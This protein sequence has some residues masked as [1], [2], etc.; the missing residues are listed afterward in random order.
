MLSIGYGAGAGAAPDVEVAQ[1]VVCVDDEAKVCFTCDEA[2][3]LDAAL[4][5][6]A[7]A[8]EACPPC[9]PPAHAWWFDALVGVAAA[10]VGL[11]AGVLLAR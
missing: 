7:A 5:E 2:R 3:D 4:T 9:P 8:A 1:E 6:C 11:A 10:A